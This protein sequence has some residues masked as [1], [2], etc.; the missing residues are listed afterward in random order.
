LIGGHAEM[1]NKVTKSLPK[2][3]QDKVAATFVSELNI[4][5]NDILLTSKKVAADIK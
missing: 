3:F 5:L 1:V 4:P 2:A